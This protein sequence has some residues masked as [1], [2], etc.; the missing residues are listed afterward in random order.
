MGVSVEAHYSR[1]KHGHMDVNEVIEYAPWVKEKFHIKRENV[2]KS[3]NPWVHDFSNTPIVPKIADFYLTEYLISQT[4]PLHLSP[5]AILVLHHVGLNPTDSKLHAIGIEATAIQ[6]ELLS[7][8][9]PMLAKYLCVALQTEITFAVYEQFFPFYSSNPAWIETIGF[10]RF[11][12][13]TDAIFSRPGSGIGKTS[14]DSGYGGPKWA[15]AGKIL[16]WWGQGNINGMPFGDKELF[17]RTANLQ[18]NGGTILNK[19]V[20]ACGLNNLGVVLDAHH[21]GNYNILAKHCS[22]NVAE[23]YKQCTSILSE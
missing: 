3:H 6:H 10:G 20:W 17:D 11:G 23:L 21:K 19:V 2:G 7:K 13:W 9:A 22:Q 4:L 18:H 5:K 15:M 8:Y 1:D 14:W 16:N 12:R